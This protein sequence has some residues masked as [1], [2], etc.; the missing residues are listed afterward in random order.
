MDKAVA[1]ADALH[2]LPRL[3]SAGDRI[4]WTLEHFEETFFAPLNAKYPE[5]RGLAPNAKK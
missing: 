2:Y 3:L 1:I 5:L 4:G